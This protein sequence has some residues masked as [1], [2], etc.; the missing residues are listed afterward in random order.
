LTIP[1][2]TRRRS[3]SGIGPTTVKCFLRGRLI[4]G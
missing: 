3:G 1:Y 2:S 4:V